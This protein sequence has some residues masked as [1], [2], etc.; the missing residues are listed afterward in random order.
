MAKQNF[1]LGPKAI[2]DVTRFQ[3]ILMRYPRVERLSMLR[4]LGLSIGATTL[5]G[6]A[7][8][9]RGIASSSR[10][11]VRT[12]TGAFAKESGGAAAKRTT[13]ARARRAA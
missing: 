1:N 4:W 3:A 9:V 2:Q 6:G 13:R 10:V 8:N 5:V 7:S 12:A 11:R